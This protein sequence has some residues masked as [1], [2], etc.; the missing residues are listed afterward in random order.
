MLS[1]RNRP[2]FVLAAALAAGLLCST[3]GAAT[4]TVSNL[5]NDGPGSLRDSVRISTN[6]DTVVVALAGSVVLNSG[7]IPIGVDLTIE[8]PATDEFIVAANGSRAFNVFAGNVHMSKL[9]ISGTELASPGRVGEGGA[10]LN[11][12]TLTLSECTVY[13]SFAA[14]GAGSGVG[15][16][17]AIANH[18]SLTVLR[19]TFFGN[20]AVGGDGAYGGGGVGGPGGDAAGGTIYNAGEMSLINSTINGALATGGRG[21]DGGAG[22][23]RGGNGYGGAIYNTRTAWV[24]NCTIASNAARGGHGGNGG[25]GGN[26]EGGGVFQ[27]ADAGTTLPR[28]VIV[29]LNG[30]S[31]GFGPNGYGSGPDVGGTI[32]SQGHNLIGR[33]DGSNGWSA[34]DL[35]GGSTEGTRLDPQLSDLQDNGGPTLTRV[36]APS[37]PA[38]NGGDDAALN[39]PVSPVD[40]RGFP[41]KVGARV[42]IGAV[43]RGLAQSGSTFTVTTTGEHDDGT[44]SSDDC[45]LLE[46]VNAANANPDASII[47]F[48]TGLT[49]TIE[50]LLT[51]RGLHI[52]SPLTIQGPGALDIAITAAGQ[53]RVFFVD[54]PNVV[55]SGLTIRNGRVFA[56]DGGGIVNRGTLTLSDCHILYNN[57]AGGHRGGGAVLNESGATLSLLRCAIDNNFTDRSGGAIYNEGILSATNCTFAQNF[58][59]NAGSIMS[60]VNNGQS[61]MTLRNCTITTSTAASGGAGPWEGGGGVFAEGDAQQNHVGNSLIAGNVSYTFPPT[62]PDVAGNYTSDGHNFIG[63]S[64]FST[65]FIDGMKGDQVGNVFQ[66]RDP[67]LARATNNGGHTNTAALM[68]GS[69]AINAGDD[70][71]APQTDQRGYGRSGRSDIGAFEFNGTRAQVLL[72]DVKSRKTHGN[73]GAFDIDMPLNG[74]SGVE[75]RSGPN[76]NHTLIFRFATPLSSVGKASVQSGTATIS[77]SGIGADA[78]EYVVSLSGV[79]NAQTITIALDDVVDSAGSSGS[80]FLGSMSVLLGDANGDGTVNSGDTQQTRARAGSAAAPSSLRCDYNLDGIIN[81][82]D[83][84]IVRGQSGNS[85][86]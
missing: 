70:S 24:T 49:G 39:P 30:V 40:Q 55:I 66:P 7:E 36:P 16:G 6:G 58:A 46:A 51:P 2:S 12:G 64:G 35:L 65:G 28:N 20:T 8:G 3:A 34:T 86:R 71:L 14:G 4:R 54:A 52:S 63:N 56:E 69:P 77:T 84:L 9:T 73:A 26:G 29:A 44:C 23:G 83:A 37:S 48:A 33:T 10:I 21:G 27:P 68:P 13:A 75:S 74:R 1:V 61:R 59:I 80:G 17:G 78:H 43:E 45:T 47:N 5:N 53:G 42:D 32:T 72:V 82:G 38:V 62:N 18:G 79:A 41:R 67:M 31:G 19:C 11:S 22:G 57:V 81:S 50:T 15:R 85:L 60:R 25:A 76:G